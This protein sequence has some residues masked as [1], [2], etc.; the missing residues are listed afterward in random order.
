MKTPYYSMSYT[1]DTN[2]IK[3]TLVFQTNGYVGIGFGS[4]KMQKE[5]DEYYTSCYMLYK[6]SNGQGGIVN[7]HCAGGKFN[8]LPTDTSATFLTYEESNSTN[9]NYFPTI[10]K[11]VFER[12]LN[13]KGQYPMVIG[14]NMP[15]IWFT[16]RNDNFTE[17]SYFEG[18]LVFNFEK[19]IKISFGSKIAVWFGLLMIG[20]LMAIY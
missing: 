13:Y 2:L 15:M 8:S 18:G 4:E 5:N 14:N 7:G 1:Y 12:K 17:S 20:F 19:G 9:S 10:R 11:F 3:I 16:G 6:K